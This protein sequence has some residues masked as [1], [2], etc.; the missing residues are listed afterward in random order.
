MWERLKSFCLRHKAMTALGGL[1]LLLVVF[2]AAHLQ[3]GT[4][5]NPTYCASCHQIKYDDKDY[6]PLRASQLKPD[7][8][9]AGVQDAT[10]IRISRGVQVGCAECHPQPFSEYMQSAHGL[11]KQNNRAGCLNCH[12]AH[13][14]GQFAGYMFL[15]V[16]A[17]K[18]GVGPM[19]GLKDNRMWEEKV[20]PKLAEKS[21]MRLL[22]TDSAPCRSCHVYEDI[23]SKRERGQRAH[24]CIACHYN[25]VHKPVKLSQKFNDAVGDYGKRKRKQ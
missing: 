25:L 3:F 5:S 10:P 9:R 23:M 14:I 7:V 20:R 24:T 6:A 1:A 17:W 2:G 15:N 11:T 12:E 13:T 19:A 22:E 8:L 18:Y 21:R 4:I 16:D